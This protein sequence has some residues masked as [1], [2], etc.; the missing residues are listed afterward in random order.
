[1]NTPQLMKMLLRQRAAILK[2][3]I[4]QSQG[5]PDPALEMVEELNSLAIDLVA[6]GARA[7]AAIR[8]FEHLS[9]KGG[10]S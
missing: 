1:M 8:A 10:R 2:M 5:N 9:P 3:Q 6:G 7:S 4:K